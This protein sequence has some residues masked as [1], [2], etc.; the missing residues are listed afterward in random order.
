MAGLF[1]LGK[2]AAQEEYPR[3]RLLADLRVPQRLRRMDP[4]KSSQCF[5]G[6]FH[7]A[8]LRMQCMKDNPLIQRMAKVVEQVGPWTAHNI[9]LRNDVY[10]IGRQVVCDEIRLQRILQIVADLAG[11]PIDRLRVLD[12]GFLEGM[13]AIE[14]ARR[15][16]KVVGIEGRDLHMAKARFVKDELALSNLELYLDDARNLSSE[17]HGVFD[18]ILCLGLLYH[19]NVPDVF[20][21]VEK[22][23]NCCA[24]L[25]IIDTHVSVKPKDAIEFDGKTYWG[26]AYSERRANETADQKTKK[27]WSSLDNP[28][29][30]WFTRASLYNL[31]AHAGFTSVHECHNPPELNRPFDRIL[32]TAMRGEPQRVIS[33]PLLDERLAV[34]WPETRRKNIAQC[35]R[36]YFRFAG[37]IGRCM[38][39]GFRQR[40]HPWLRRWSSVLL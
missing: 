39:I 8:V 10:T 17:K 4:A 7:G 1:A 9:H 22:I 23:A 16:A 37:M 25:A 36:W 35:Q 28:T 15:G 21:F 29:S 3:E 32:L 2:A 6:S 20:S 40:I 13:F 19:I 18:V 33:A 38:P 30:F 24:R 27:V 5:S 31:L 11:K 14:F 12:L 34:D 26:L